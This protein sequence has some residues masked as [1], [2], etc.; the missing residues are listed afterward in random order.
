MFL[1]GLVL[2]VGV[3]SY[4]AYDAYKK[5]TPSTY[6]DQKSG[7][8]S[9]NL[10]DQKGIPTNFSTALDE[11]LY[12]NPPASQNDVIVMNLPP[13]IGTATDGICGV[14]TPEEWNEYLVKNGGVPVSE[15]GMLAFMQNPSL[16]GIQLS[17][18]KTA[19]GCFPTTG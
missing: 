15:E 5:A 10:T 11:P 7:A 12:P 16:L 19:A 1:G 14:D 8:F 3:L 17:G 4:Y 6:Y 2:G 9:N 18:F 13:A